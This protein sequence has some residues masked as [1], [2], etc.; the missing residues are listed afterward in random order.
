M[1]DLE[2]RG[3]GVATPWERVCSGGE[4]KEVRRKEERGPAAPDMLS[5]SR[6]SMWRD[7]PHHLSSRHRA[8]GRRGGSVAP[9]HAAR[10]GATKRLLFANL[11]GHGLFLKI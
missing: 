2:G 3:G 10:P 6:Q 4:G 8:P 9:G 5:E 11:V 7:S 1:G